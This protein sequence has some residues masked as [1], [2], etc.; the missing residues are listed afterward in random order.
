[1]V[2]LQATSSGKPNRQE[3]SGWT[4]QEIMRCITILRICAL[5]ACLAG[6][7]RL[8]A[9]LAANYTIAPVAGAP[10]SLGDNGPAISALLWSPQGVSV[11]PAGNLY[12]A[13]SGNT[14]IRKVTPGGIIT[15]V[16]GTSP[17]FSGD[18]GPA[19]VAQ[20]SYPAKAVASSNGDIYVVDSANNRIRRV[21]PNGIISTV[22]GT[23]Q[24]GFAGEGDLALNAQ[25][26][27]PRD[28]AIDSTGSLIVLD[29]NNRRL[30]RFSPGGKITTIAG[31]GV[32][33]LF[34]DQGPATQAQFASPWGFAVDSSGNIYIADT[35][36]HR[37]RKITSDGTVTSIAG[38]NS[39]GFSGDNGPASFAQLNRPTSVAV[40]SAGNV[41]IADTS[42]HRMRKIDARG[43][44]TTVA[45]TGAN[46]F[47]GD[48]GPAS[49]AQL[50]L[51]E[52]VAVDA[53]GNILVADTGNHRIRRISASGM[54]TTIAGSDPGAGDNGPAAR[55]LLFQ[56]SGVA[57]DTSGNLYIADSSNNRIRRVAIDGNIT[58]VAGTGSS[59]YSGDNGSAQRAQLNGPTGITFD[60]TGSLYIADT[61]NNVIRRVAGGVIT[62][63]AGTGVADNTGDG[64][65]ALTATLYN[66]SAVAFDRSGNMLIADSANNRIRVVNGSGIITAFAG[67]PAGLPGDAGDNGPARNAVFDYPIAL[68][69]DPSNNVY[70][71]DYFNNRVR[72]ISAGTAVITAFA[73]TGVPGAGGDGGSA[74]QARLHLPAGIS[75]DRDQNLYIADLLNN[76]IRVVSTNGVISTIAGVGVPGQGGDFG[77]ALSAFLAS[78]RDV[79]VD[80]TGNVYFSD[81]DNDAVRRLSAQST[82]IR[83]IV[84]AASGSAG[85]VAPGEAVTIL[86]SRLG[87]NTGVSGT[88]GSGAYAASL[89]GTRV[90]FD[91][92]AA[93]LLYASTNQINLIVPYEIAGR[94]S[95]QVRVETNGIPGDAFTLTVRD[96][97]PGLFTTDSS[98]QGQ[99]AAVN[100]N[101]RLNSAANPAAPGSIIALYATGEGQTNPAGSSGRVV[102]GDV[103]ALPQPLQK[104]VVLIQGIPAQILYAGAAPSAAGLMQINVRI[105]ASVAPSDRVLV[106]LAVGSFAAQP[107]VTIAVR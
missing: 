12:I 40:D 24:S 5:A 18:A 23:G 66:P 105:P 86:G 90:L 52:S 92:I 87:P 81:Q 20:L 22:A 58:T 21:A 48:N 1:M 49:S 100:E 29:T 94:S 64:G 80:A 61:G 37:I 106:D 8:E 2:S 54:I 103:N 96:A 11:D 70:V 57:F 59:G 9:Q 95:V 51:P 44:I 6:G 4:S 75:F 84:N 19:S 28:I 69:V 36:N 30:R 10:R 83:T 68:A 47:A 41:Y 25:F 46:G 99:A 56:P 79:A 89:S 78:P 93:P 43:T 85:F 91:G 27:Y 33:G 42:N 62:T 7:T 67:D 97:S 17:G 101:G 98:G 88:G 39:P 15:T 82:S 35:F 16:A 72:K 26:S 32:F 14:R 45:G 107:G 13:D 53:G 74:A 76:R 63:V 71:S 31:S 38:Q 77:P 60:R 65:P 73:G 34:G 102:G 3:N 50:N 55:A 104:V